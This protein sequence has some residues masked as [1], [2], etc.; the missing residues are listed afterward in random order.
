MDNRGPKKERIL[1]VDYDLKF[2]KELWKTLSVEFTVNMATKKETADKIIMKYLGQFVA[3]IIGHSKDGDPK[4]EL[5]SWYKELDPKIGTIVLIDTGSQTQESAYADEFLVRDKNTPNEI[6]KHVKNVIFKR[7]MSRHLRRRR[8]LLLHNL[9]GKTAI[10]LEKRESHTDEK[11]GEVE[12]LTGICTK[13]GA[14][15]RWVGYN[16]PEH[17]KIFTIGVASCIGCGKGCGFCRSGKRKFIRNLEYDEIIGQVLHGL[18]SYYAHGLFNEKNQLTP[19]VNFTCEGDA[20]VCNLDN[21]ARAI[22]MLAE[23]EELN[24][25]FIITSIGSEKGLEKYLEK[26]SYLPRLRHYWSVN[27]LDPEIRAEIM[28]YTK[29]DSLERLR[30]RYQKIAE[31]TNTK[32]TVSWILIKGKTD[33]EKDAEMLN[34]FFGNRPFIVKIQPLV[35]IDLPHFFQT[36][37]EDLINFKN[38]LDKRNIET[39]VRNIIGTEIFAGCGSTIPTFSKLNIWEKFP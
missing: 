8:F 30:D 35:H 13:D 12:A 4:L 19:F 24:F 23:I 26:Y 36:S 20:L 31:K 34:D 18:N 27:S 37:D 28:P 22:E 11:G 15:I 17:E 10:K 3:V 32:I 1:L 39:R 16:L 38:L 9:P 2:L 29:G 33:R 25:N 6:L 21:S 5:A 14:K 7:K